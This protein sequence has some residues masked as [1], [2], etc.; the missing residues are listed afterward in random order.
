MKKVYVK[1]DM[2]VIVKRIGHHLLAG[3]VTEQL[4]GAANMSSG[5]FDARDFDFYDE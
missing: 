3:S 4:G 5:S 2:T 1:P